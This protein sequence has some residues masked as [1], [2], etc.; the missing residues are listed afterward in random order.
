VPGGGGAA[1]LGAERALQGGAAPRNTEAPQF[2][3]SLIAPAA[4]PAII[5]SSARGR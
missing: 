1:R 3:R 4:M 2:R 5:W